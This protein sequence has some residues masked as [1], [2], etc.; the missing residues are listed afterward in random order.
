MIEHYFE[1]LDVLNRLRSHTIGSYADSFARS[2]HEQGYTYW[3]V[4]GYLRAI[5]HLGSWLDRTKVSLARLDDDVVLRFK[6]HLRL[7]RCFRQNRGVFAPVIPG[8]RLFMAHLCELEVIAAPQ[9]Q[10]E[11]HSRLMASF[12]TWMHRHRGVTSSTLD[13]YE[14]LLAQFIAFA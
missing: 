10:P 14:R 5:G 6:K 11:T 9:V 1:K 2:L 7:C 12:R 13:V 3:V 4:R 8:V